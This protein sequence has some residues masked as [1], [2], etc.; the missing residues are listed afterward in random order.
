[1]DAD[2]AIRTAMGLAP[3]DHDADEMLH[4]PEGEHEAGEEAAEVR[5]SLNSIFARYQRL[6]RLNEIVTFEREPTVE[7]RK[8][9]RVEEEGSASSERPDKRARLEDALRG[10]SDLEEAVDSLFEPSS[11]EEEGEEGEGEDD[12]EYLPSNCVLCGKGDTYFKALRREHVTKFNRY[13]EKFLPGMPIAECAQI[14]RNFYRKQIHRPGYPDIPRAM[15]QAHYEMNHPGNGILVLLNEFD[16]LEENVYLMDQQLGKDGQVLDLADVETR[17][18]YSLRLIRIHQ[19]KTEEIKF[20]TR[21]VVQDDETEDPNALPTGYTQRRP[22]P[23]ELILNANG[24]IRGNDDDPSLFEEDDE[25]G[26]DDE[27]PVMASSSHRCACILCLYGNAYFDSIEN[28]SAIKEFYIQAN[29]Q[30]KTSEYKQASEFLARFYQNSVYRPGYPRVTASM[31]R[32]HYERNHPRSGELT[33]LN[34]VRTF[35]KI[36]HLLDNE[37]KIPGLK[38]EKKRRRVRLRVGDHIRMLISIDG[39]SLVFG[40]KTSI[41]L[42]IG[43]LSSLPFGDTSKSQRQKRALRNMDAI[44]RSAH[45]TFV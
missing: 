6:H 41:D 38:H 17:I 7:S 1:M 12:I 32:A 15:I 23:D 42:Q 2:D 9:A 30:I 8:R 45:V 44:S 27:A 14:L 26:E 3:I 5:Y 36:R 25:E 43:Y 40:G 22:D 29:R 18:A 35:N 13:A 34:E 16:S 39:S 37:I 10:E 20:G 31:I 24:T 19:T 33:I 21:A 4:G 11:S 28:D